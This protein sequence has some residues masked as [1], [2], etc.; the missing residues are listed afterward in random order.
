MIRFLIGVMVGFALGIT[1]AALSS[2]AKKADEEM[3]IDDKN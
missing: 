3:G 2:M 1:I